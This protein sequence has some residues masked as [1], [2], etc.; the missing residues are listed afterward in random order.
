MTLS[1]KTVVAPEYFMWGT[2]FPN[3]MFYTKDP[4]KIITIFDIDKG[5]G[6]LGTILQ[7]W[8]ME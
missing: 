1:G 8:D 2:D 7:I 5:N 6:A 3:E 4:N